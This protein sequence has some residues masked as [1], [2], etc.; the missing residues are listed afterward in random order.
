[1]FVNQSFKFKMI[2]YLILT[3]IDKN[4]LN[5]SETYL[6]ISKNRLSIWQLTLKKHREKETR[7]I[8]RQ[9][10]WFFPSYKVL[11]SLH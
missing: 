8:L 5:D 9:V 1:M 2:H 10:D 11:I 7:L 4:F 6:A 3:S